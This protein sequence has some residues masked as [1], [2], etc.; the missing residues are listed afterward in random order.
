[1][2]LFCYHLFF[3]IYLK[4]QV[5]MGKIS[6]ENGVICYPSSPLGSRS[7]I[8]ISIKPFGTFP[9]S[10]NFFEFSLKSANP[11][12]VW[13][14]FQINDVQIAGVHKIPHKQRETILSPKPYFSSS[15]ERGNYEKFSFA[16]Y[17][18]L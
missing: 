11:T 13:Q 17:V 1:M 7:K 2:P 6:G 4:P 8:H 3:K 5:R 15:R 10:K 12:M 18:L 16:Q 14:Y 9:L